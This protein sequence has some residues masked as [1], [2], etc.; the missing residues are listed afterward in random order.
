ML[1]SLPFAVALLASCTAS[2]FVAEPAPQ[3]AATSIF[4]QID[5]NQLSAELGRPLKFKGRVAVNTFN[6]R[7]LVNLR[8]ANKRAR[9]GLPPKTA[10]TEGN[11]MA[12]AGFVC[13]VIG[14]FIFPIVLPQLAII[15]SAIGMRKSNR[16]GA[17]LR[18]L[19]IAGLVTG[20]LGSLLTLLLILAIAIA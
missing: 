8:K 7:Q 15:F 9:K 2:A 13:G 11:G 18:G 19:A 12:I 14:L 10:Y 20:I 1:R 16:E 17:P 5:K 3:A 4:Q 6:R